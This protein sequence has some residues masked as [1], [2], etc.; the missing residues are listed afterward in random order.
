MARIEE[1]VEI[2]CSPQ[3]LFAYTTDAE[4]WSKWQ[5][6]IPSAEQTSSG[7]VNVGS[8]FKGRSRMMGLSMGWTAVATECDPVRSFGKTITSPAMI[9]EQHNT[10]DPLSAGVKFTIR[11]DMRVRGLFKVFSPMLVSAM[12]KGLRRSLGN[13]KHNVEAQ[14]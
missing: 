2:G 13:L 9:V 7:A 6:I 12:R 4:T 14:Q 1:S 8:T 5:S 3:R 10:Y 11:Y